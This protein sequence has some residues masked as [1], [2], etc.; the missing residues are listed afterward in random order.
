MPL[1]LTTPSNVSDT[2]TAVEITDFAAR[3]TP[4][5]VVV[6]FDLKNSNGD[7]LRSSLLTLAG[8]DFVQA[9]SDANAAADAMA[10]SV[11]VYTALKAALYA[12]IE[13][14][15]GLSGTVV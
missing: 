12:A 3:T 6:S 2:I 14:I 13:R 9:L 1:N 10:G 5:E 11:D 7:V 4:P 8:S 15:T